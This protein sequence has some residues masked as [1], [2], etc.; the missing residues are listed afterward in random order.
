METEIENVIRGYFDEEAGAK[1][2]EGDGGLLY[3]HD[4]NWSFD[5]KRLAALIAERLSAFE[6]KPTKA[7][8]ALM[9]SLVKVPPMQPWCGICR[10]GVDGS[11]CSC[12]KYGKPEEGRK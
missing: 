10:P 4:S 7:D 6:E 2:E 9:R 3:D 1:L 8:A 12:G 11:W 5:P